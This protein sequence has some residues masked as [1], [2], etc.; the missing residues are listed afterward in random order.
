M[1]RDQE[2]IRDL[3][4]DVKVLRLA[5]AAL[6]ELARRQEAG[7]ALVLVVEPLQGNV[8]GSNR[9]FSSTAVPAAGSSVEPLLILR[10]QVSAAASGEWSQSGTVWIL[11]EAPQ[12]DPVG[13]VPDPQPIAVYLKDPEAGTTG[14]DAVTMGTRRRSALVPEPEEPVPGRSRRR[15]VLVP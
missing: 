11:N 4:A 13:Q 3:E 15:R 5:L 10:G 7:N 12:V 2:R 1:T 8:D 14:F 6:Q 9:L